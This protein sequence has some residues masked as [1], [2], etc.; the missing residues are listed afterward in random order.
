MMCMASSPGK[1]DDYAIRVHSIGTAKKYPNRV[2]FGLLAY[3]IYATDPT[4][5]Y[6]YLILNTCSVSARAIC[7]PDT[8]QALILMTAMCR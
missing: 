1:T 5:N 6:F 3:A 4:R 2:G 7:I 8:K